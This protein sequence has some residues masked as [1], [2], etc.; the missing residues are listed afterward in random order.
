MKKENQ[1]PYHMQNK[2][3]VQKLLLQKLCREHR[4]LLYK[5]AAD[6]TD[7]FERFRFNPMKDP[8]EDN[9]K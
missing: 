1:Y 8:S 6:T 2:L 3:M 7:L 9:S 5:K 4:N